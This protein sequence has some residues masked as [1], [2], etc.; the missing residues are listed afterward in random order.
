MHGAMNHLTNETEYTFDLISDSDV[1]ALSSSK[2]MVCTHHS[3]LAL[4]TSYYITLLRLP[5]PLLPHLHQTQLRD[6]F[7]G[8]L[9][10]EATQLSEACELYVVNKDCPPPLHH[11]MHYGV[12]LSN[13]F[14]IGTIYPRTFTF[15][16]I[17]A[18]RYED[19]MKYQLFFTNSLE[20]AKVYSPTTT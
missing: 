5:S 17:H 16:L 7:G 18:W 6:R 15:M 8:F 10:V 3:L 9:H 11:F 4:F 1:H 20:S 12:I 19:K 2:M 13:C 14:A